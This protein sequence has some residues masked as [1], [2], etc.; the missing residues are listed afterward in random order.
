MTV[1]AA[2]SGP[3][4]LLGLLDHLLNTEDAGSMNFRNVWNTT[5]NDTTLL[6]GDLRLH[7]TKSVYILC[8]EYSFVVTVSLRFAVRSHRNKF[9]VN[10]HRTMT[11]RVRVYKSWPLGVN[12]HGKILMNQ[13]S[14]V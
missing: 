5:P 4:T 6:Q 3:R 12:C 10:R 7:V 2:S 13:R 9:E 11:F 14:G 1:L 8:S